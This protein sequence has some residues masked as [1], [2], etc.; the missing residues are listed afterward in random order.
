MKGGKKTRK[1]V[2]GKKDARESNDTHCRC[3]EDLPSILKE[4]RG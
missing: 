1:I 4:L 2:Q 3:H